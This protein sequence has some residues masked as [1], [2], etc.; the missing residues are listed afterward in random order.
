M[1]AKLIKS[2]K[3]V[4]KLKDKLTTSDLQGIVSAE[5]RKFGFKNESQAEDLFIDYAENVNDLKTT[6][7]KLEKLK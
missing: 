4:K 2:L 1:K 5:V 3:Y 6:L 7:K